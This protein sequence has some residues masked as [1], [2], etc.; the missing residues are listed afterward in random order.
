[1]WGL[2]GPQEIRIFN[3]A[4]VLIIKAGIQLSLEVYEIDTMDLI[5]SKNFGVCK[6]HVIRI[7]REATHYEK[8][9]ANHTSIRELAS[10][11]KNP[12][13]ST[14]KEHKPI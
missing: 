1:M 9:V 10:R 6:C 12:K 4:L 8:G 3:A 11:I 13:N 14:V 2:V 7:K 5:K